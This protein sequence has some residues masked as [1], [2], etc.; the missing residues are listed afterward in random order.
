MGQDNR[1]K[2]HES[3]QIQPD[4]SVCSLGEVNYINMNMQLSSVLFNWQTLTTEHGQLY[5]SHTKTKEHRS[6]N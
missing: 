2:N 6:Y 5:S 1:F 3:V 4:G